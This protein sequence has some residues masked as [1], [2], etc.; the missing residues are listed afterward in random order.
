MVSHLRMC[1]RYN[2]RWR[3]RILWGYQN[4]VVIQVFFNLHKRQKISVFWWNWSLFL[5]KLKAKWPINRMPITESTLFLLFFF[6]ILRVLG[7]R[8]PKI[9]HLMHARR[10]TA[11]LVR[12]QIGN[13][14]PINTHSTPTFP[15]IKFLTLWPAKTH[16]SVT[17]KI[18]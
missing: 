8:A 5:I 4:Q 11:V 3:G 7:A 12:P 15:F 14:K 18:L 2:S 6:E 13:E 9:D 1:E 17:K 16:T 10:L